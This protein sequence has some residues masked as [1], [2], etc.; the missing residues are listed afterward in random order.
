MKIVWTSL[1]RIESEG[2]I[3]AAAACIALLTC[4][5]I[6]LGLLVRKVRAY[7]VVK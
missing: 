6:C 7:E 5:A 2:D 3:S 4:C 1:F